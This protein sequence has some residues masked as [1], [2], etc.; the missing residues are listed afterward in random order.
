M[1]ESM[2]DSETHKRSCAGYSE[3][4]PQYAAGEPALSGSRPE[5]VW[6]RL[7]PGRKHSPHGA[8]PLGGGLATDGKRIYYAPKWVL[9]RYRKEKEAIVRDYL[10]MVFHCV[11]HHA[12]VDTLLDIPRWD[13]ACDIAAESAIEDLH[14][15]CATAIRRNEQDA[16]VRK[17]PK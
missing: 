6:L 3:I 8:F 13:L 7:L 9:L 10:H 1:G 4:E 5:H 17:L 2:N 12:F 15:S 11:F 14:L 16:F